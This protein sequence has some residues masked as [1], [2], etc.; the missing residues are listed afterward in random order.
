MIFKP[1]QEKGAAS[2]SLLAAMMPVAV[3][4]MPLITSAQPDVFTARYQTFKRVITC[5]HVYTTRMSTERTFHSLVES[6]KPMT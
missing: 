2:R 5:N 3:I 4:G 6:G 1:F